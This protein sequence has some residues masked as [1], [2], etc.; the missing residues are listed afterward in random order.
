MGMAILWESVQDN[1]AISI[2]WE[3]WDLSISPV[4]SHQLQ[5]AIEMD[6][7]LIRVTSHVYSDV[8]TSGLRALLIK[9]RHYNH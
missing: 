8:L 7:N 2:S 4:I 1:G 9:Q 5:L 6:M 3:P